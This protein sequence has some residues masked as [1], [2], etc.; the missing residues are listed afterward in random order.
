MKMLN[1]NS[2]KNRFFTTTYRVCKYADWDEDWGTCAITSVPL[3]SEALIG[4]SGLEEVRRLWKSANAKRKSQFIIILTMAKE[5]GM[6]VVFLANYSFTMSHSRQ[7]KQTIHWRTT[8]EMPM[9]PCNT[10]PAASVCK[11][12]YYWTLEAFVEPNLTLRLK[13]PSSNSSSLRNATSIQFKG[14]FHCAAR[15][16]SN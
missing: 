10:M 15:G 12:Y 5:G 4:E 3:G 14:Y 7:Y 1:L 6:Q 2:P 13:I 9:R 8:I 11:T 16:Q